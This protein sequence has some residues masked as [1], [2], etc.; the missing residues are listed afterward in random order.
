M[1]KFTFQPQ[2]NFG[3]KFYIIMSNNKI[4]ELVIA[5]MQIRVDVF[6]KVHYKYFGSIN[7]EPMF[8]VYK[9]EDDWYAQN[10]KCFKTKEELLRSL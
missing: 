6:Q 4:Y 10:M 7:N 9:R 1:K 3:D 2:L 8:T 5:A